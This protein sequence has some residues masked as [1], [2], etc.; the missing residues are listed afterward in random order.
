MATK[1]ATPKRTAKKPMP[2]IQR[3]WDDNAGWERGEKAANKAR[4]QSTK[5]TA[6]KLKG[7]ALIRDG[8]RR[9]ERGEKAAKKARASAIKR[10]R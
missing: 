7:E 9:W 1:K 5:P 3:I 4:A 6:T 10:K 8:N 2:K